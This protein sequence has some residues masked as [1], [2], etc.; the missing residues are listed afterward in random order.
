MEMF[1]EQ[2]ISSDKTKKISNSLKKIAGCTFYNWYNYCIRI[3]FN[4]NNS[5]DISFVNFY[6][7]LFYVY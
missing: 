1:L 5:R 7:K 2:F 3:I 4:C 6:R